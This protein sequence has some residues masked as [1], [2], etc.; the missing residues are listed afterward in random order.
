ILSYT[1][2]MYSGNPFK[3][4]NSFSPQVWILIAVSFVLYGALNWLNMRREHRPNGQR[5]L[6]LTN[7]SEM[8]ALLLGQGRFSLSVSVLYCYVTPKA[9]SRCRADPD[10]GIH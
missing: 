9:V 4:F 7:L 8:F 6:M 10:F 3:I 5:L 2:P 1:K